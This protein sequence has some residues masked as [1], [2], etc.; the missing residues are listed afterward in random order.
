MH[1]FQKC[2]RPKKIE[3]FTKERKILYQA[4]ENHVLKEELKK[5]QSYVFSLCHPSKLL[6]QIVIVGFL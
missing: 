6:E 4:K 2:E 1:L 3:Y 5:E